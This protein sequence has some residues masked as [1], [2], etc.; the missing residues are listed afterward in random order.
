MFFTYV[1][2]ELRRRRRQALV[3]ALGLALGIGLVVTVSSMAAGVRTA[4]SQVLKSLYGVGTDITVTQAAAAG[5]GPGA[6]FGLNP[7]DQGRQGQSFS[8]DQILASPGLGSLRTKQVARVASLAHV[9][10]ASGGLSLTSIHAEGKFADFGNLDAGG[11]AS[12]PA[13]TARPSVPP[14]RISSYSILGVDVGSNGVGPLTSSDITSGRYFASSENTAKVAILDRSYAKQRK[15]KVGSTISIDGTK[16]SVIGIAATPNGGDASNVYL[17][18]GRAQKLA[19]MSGKVNRIYVKASSASAIAQVKAEIEKALPKATVTTAEDLASQVTGSLASASSLAKNLG[20]WL[21]IAA[22]I[23][24]FAVASLLTVSAVG[25]RVREFGTLKALGW[26]SRRVVGQVMGEAM[27]QGVLGGVLGIG[28]GV[29]GALLVSKLS[30]SLKATVGATATGPGGG[31]VAAFV[32]G[33]SGGPVRSAV[34]AASRTVTVP[35]TAPLNVKLFA[36]AIGLALIGGILAGTL[37][38][39]RAARLRPAEALRRVE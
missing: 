4:Q 15:L 20:T 3:V 28:V 23:A 24:A 11:V 36:L 32:G 33:P 5:T 27:V 18:L 8:R 35:L 21:S 17:P 22:L 25:R 19:G 16:Y 9:A 31:P 12:G 10:A 29:G 37:G 30:P 39:W 38:G 6:R 2:R 13:P 7:A 1:A 14:I 26:R 34:A